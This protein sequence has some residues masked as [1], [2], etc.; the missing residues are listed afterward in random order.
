[1]HRSRTFSPTTW[2]RS[3]HAY[4]LLASFLVVCAAWLAGMLLKWELFSTPRRSELATLTPPLQRIVQPGDGFFPTPIPIPDFPDGVE[5]INTNS[6]L[7]LS[8]LKGK[9]VLLDFWTYCCIN[10]MHILPTLDAIEKKYDKQL[11]VVGV[12]TAKFTAEKETE[13]IREAIQRYDIRHPVFNDPDHVLWNRLQIGSWPTLVLL[14]PQ[15]RAVWANAG[16]IEFADLDRVMQR[17]VTYYQRRGEIDTRSV[18]FTLESTSARA[19]SLRF[20]GKVLVDEQGSRLFISDSNHNRIA[21]T[22]LSGKLL[23]T[24]GSGAVGAKDGDFATAVFNQ[25]QGMALS[26]GTLFVADTKNHLLRAVDLNR[27]VVTTI[28]GTG[29]QTRSAWLGAAPNSPLNRRP[30]RPPLTTDLASPWDLLVHD[31]T[32]FIAM[33][34]THQIWSMDLQGKAIGPYA[35]NGREDI[36]DG[37]LLPRMP[38]ALGSASFAQPSGLASDGRQIYVADS[39]G[40]SVRAVPLSGIGKVTTVA[41]TSTLEKNRLFVFGDKDGPLDSATFQ[42]PLGIAYGAGRIFVADTYNDKIREIDLVKGVVTTLVGGDAGTDRPNAIQ[43]DEPSG[44]SL[45]KNQLYIADTNHHRICVFDIA[46]NEARE[47]TIPDLKPPQAMQATTPLRLPAGAVEQEIAAIVVAPTQTEIELPIHYLLPEGWKL[48]DLAPQ[49]YVAVWK[50]AAGTIVEGE[51]RSGRIESPGAQVSLK[52]A[53]PPTANLKLQLGLVYY[54]CRKDG[55]GLCFADATII[56]A[57]VTRGATTKPQP[58]EVN[59]LPKE[60]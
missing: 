16:E 4:C 13:N 1:L 49:S 42:H 40:S 23:H 3:L 9:L 5:W 25:P 59:I 15:G 31:Q 45:F 55:A 2:A 58:I 47:L 52:L 18:H 38:Y 44:L 22:D 17:A 41:G 21:V 24:I 32:L 27:R 33:A 26:S 34:G 57:K 10:C 51:T 56:S 19:T 29:K 28:A 37:P 35:G 39:E 30:S 11:V 8:D 50:D 12:H 36:V 7:Q 14:D 6:K 46:T 53:I 54:Y 60:Q 48:N 20:P 43:L